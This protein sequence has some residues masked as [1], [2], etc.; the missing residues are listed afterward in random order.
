MKKF[1]C[2]INQPPYKNSHA[3]ECIET[4]MVA[5]VF[6]FKVSLLFRGEGVWA[7][8][9]AQDASVLGQRTFSKVLTALPTY[10]IESLFVSTEDLRIRN[11]RSNDLCLPLSLLDYKH[12]ANLIN[13]QDVVIGCDA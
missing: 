12:Q 10:E 7:L 9:K 4:A 5:A 2:I 6:D 13:D 11:L 8:Q 3:L 1:L